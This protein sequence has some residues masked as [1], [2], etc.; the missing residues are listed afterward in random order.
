MTDNDLGQATEHQDL[1]DAKN[2]PEEQH[3]QEENTAVQSKE[4]E[5]INPITGEKHDQV[6]VKKTPPI[7]KDNK[8]SKDDKPI[9]LIQLESSK[10]ELFTVFYDIFFTYLT[11]PSKFDI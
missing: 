5:E 3:E 10:Y 7:Q 4:T 8:Q 9:K 11:L 1:D 2:T 6:P